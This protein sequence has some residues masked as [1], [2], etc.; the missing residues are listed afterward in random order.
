M[1]RGM[2]AVGFFNG[3]VTLYD[4]ESKQ[5]YTSDVAERDAGINDILMY[6]HE[7]GT[8]IVTAA[9]DETIKMFDLT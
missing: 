3:T 7:A 9:E 4:E 8:K 2:Y 5:L 6:N 1:T